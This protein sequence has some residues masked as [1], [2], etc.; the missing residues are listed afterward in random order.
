MRTEACKHGGTCCP[1]LP[2]TIRLA[3]GKE[4]P[5]TGLL[6]RGNRLA[7]IRVAGCRAAMCCIAM[8]AASA[9]QAAPKS[10]Y[11]LPDT[12]KGYVS[13]GD[14]PALREAFNRSQWGQLVNDPVLQDF[15]KDFQRQLHEAGVQRLQGLGLSWDDFDGVPTGEVSLATIQPSEGRMAVV[16]LVDV[17]GHKTQAAGLVAKIE[18]RLNERGAQRL[19]HDDGGPVIFELPQQAGQRRIHQVAYFLSDE[20]LAASDDAE[21]LQAVAAAA[22]NGRKDNLA[23][24]KSFNEIM[25]RCAK[26]AGATAPHI[27]WFVDPF[28][29]IGM[30][31]SVKPRERHRGIDLYQSLK[32]QGF[33]AVQ[34]VGGYVNFSSDRCE[35]IHRTFVYAPPLPGHESSKDKYELAARMLNFPAISDL[36]PEQWVPKQVATYNSFTL[37]VKSAFAASETLVDEVMA[38]KGVFHDVLDSLK[39]DPDGPKVDIITDLVGN[40]GNRITVIT[41]YELPIGPKSERLL[42]AIDVKNEQV[43]A[44]TIEKL[45][46]G[47]AQRREFEGHVIWE[48][49]DEQ[50]A[51]PDLK[52]DNPN[53]VNH[54]DQADDEARAADAKRGKDG[55]IPANSAMTVAYGHLFAASHMS[56]LQKILHQA[57]EQ[58]GL[59]TCADY[60]MIADQSKKLGAG[61]IS[62]RLFSRTDEEYRPTYELIRTGRM[63]Q[64]ETLLGQLLN[65]MLGEGKDGAPR[66]QKIDGRTLPEFD[67]VSHYFGPAGT[68]VASEKN[69]WFLVGFTMNKAVV[70]G[71]TEG[72][73][74]A[75]PSKVAPLKVVPTKATTPVEQTTVAPQPAKP[76]AASASDESASALP[77]PAILPGPA[78]VPG[79]AEQPSE[80]VTGKK[81]GITTTK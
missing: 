56:F 16:V 14:V 32:N 77:G 59:A 28:G 26:S 57:H 65:A 60:R 11:L 35:L 49:A 10:E 40:L 9:V 18:S 39:N 73:V 29:Y 22:K 63:P 70:N 74:V 69:G 42:V 20:L 80:A 64:A 17:T 53:G 23:S 62:F 47:D 5:V 34:G 66:K 79:T 8:L 54:A 36:E 67:A 41:D 44:S 31:R 75:S 25:T 38:E 61:D 21:V 58:G 78:A 13:V 6:S 33:M 24:V 1:I 72:N 50:V 52:I 76:D 71:T 12:T 4:Q 3:F 27:R 43:V 81:P 15:V 45:M 37:D 48:I 19:P 2:S 55:F 51:V 46:K 68:F 7:A 30:V